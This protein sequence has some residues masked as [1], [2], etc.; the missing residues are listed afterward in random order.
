MNIA[1]MTKWIWRLFDPSEQ[2]KLWFKLLQ[3]KY[4]NSDNIYD[5]S[6]QGGSQFRRS[7]NKI[8]HFFKLGSRFVVGNGR[9]MF[10]WTD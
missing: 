3:A 5:A 6:T 8:K 2:D 4:V 9:K 10:F 7:L 1:L